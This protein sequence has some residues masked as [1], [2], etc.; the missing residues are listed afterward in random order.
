[1]HTYMHACLCAGVCWWIDPAPIVTCP[2]VQHD[3]PLPCLCSTNRP[4]PNQTLHQV[5]YGPQ[6]QNAKLAAAFYCVPVEED[7]DTPGPCV[8]RLMHSTRR[9][10]VV[11]WCGRKG[12]S[13]PA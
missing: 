7:D 1:M 12:G 2:T 10:V 6:G 4:T 5:V 11:D 8:V 3:R 9:C 13:A